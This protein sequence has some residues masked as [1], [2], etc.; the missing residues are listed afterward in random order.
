MAIYDQVMEAL[1]RADASGNSDDA[2]RLA[3]RL[4]RVAIRLKQQASLMIVVLVNC[5]DQNASF[6]KIIRRPLSRHRFSVG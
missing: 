3:A 6:V 2:K 5:A 1:R 4:Y